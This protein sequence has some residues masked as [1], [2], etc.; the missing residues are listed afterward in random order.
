MVELI[1]QIF[2]NLSVIAFSLLWVSASLMVNSLMISMIA[3]MRGAPNQ[4]R[5]MMRFNI[6]GSLFLSALSSSWAVIAS[7]YATGKWSYAFPVFLG[8]AWLFYITGALIALW[9]HNMKFS[10]GGAQGWFWFSLA[11]LSKVIQAKATT[12][13]LSSLRPSEMKMYE[14]EQAERDQELI[15]AL[16]EAAPDA[17]VI[18]AMPPI[19]P[20]LFHTKHLVLTPAMFVA[21]LPAGA[22]VITAIADEKKVPEVTTPIPEV[23]KP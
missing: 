11:K 10:P 6:G 2:P 18:V 20:L 14:L 7:Y 15:R 21:P 19:A 13:A 9:M 3:N 17:K 22:A 1:Q 12:M 4:V 16:A 8:I 23:I 5:F